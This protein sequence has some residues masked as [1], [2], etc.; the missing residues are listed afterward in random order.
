[1]KPRIVLL[2]LCAVFLYGCQR[3]FDVNISSFSQP[4][5]MADKTC[6]ILPGFSS[7]HPSDLQ[8]REFEPYVR[9]ALEHQGYRVI[10]DN[11]K[12]AIEILLSYTTIGPVFGGY[13]TNTSSGSETYAVYASTMVGAHGGGRTV[14]VPGYDVVYSTPAYPTY[15][16]LKTIGLEAWDA[17][18]GT[19]EP[20]GVQFWKMMITNSGSVS[21]LREAFPAMM[22]AAM[23]YIGQDTKKAVSVTVK[24]NDPKVLYIKGLEKLTTP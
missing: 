22:A 24:E 11:Q 23:D 2:S 1:M 20:Q 19:K 12:A 10:D 8:F 7:I 15:V 5:A 16:Y 18:K 6:V 9:R 4:T 17:Q 21:D 3:S 14:F 13:S